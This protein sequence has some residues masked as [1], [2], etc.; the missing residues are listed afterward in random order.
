MRAA[1]F[2]RPC[3]LESPPSPRPPRRGFSFAAFRAR[4]QRR[5]RAGYLARCGALAQDETPAAVLNSRCSRY[6]PT[7]PRR[8]TGGV[9][10]APP[11][12]WR[13]Q[14]VLRPNLS[15]TSTS[16]VGTAAPSAHVT[17]A[18]ILCG[19]DRSRPGANFSSRTPVSDGPILFV[20]DDGA[21]YVQKTLNTF[22]AGTSPDSAWI[23]VR[24]SAA[25]GLNC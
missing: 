10:R 5:G 15:V 18:T 16:G 6:L 9:F 14:A 24:R 23:R 2:H 13:D 21:D 17:N 19:T 20:A 11:S 7:S 3:R 1:A 22:Q 8:E 4:L 12:C 25:N